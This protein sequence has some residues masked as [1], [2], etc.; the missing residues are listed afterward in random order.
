MAFPVAAD[1]AE[2]AAFASRLVQAIFQN[3]GESLKTQ[4]DLWLA[5]IPQALSNPENIGQRTVYNFVP[6]GRELSEAIPT[7]EAS[8][9]QVNA[10]DLTI[11][12]W[13]CA[14]GIQGA[15]DGSR[16]SLAQYSALLVSWNGI[17]V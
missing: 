1:F 10:N 4:L 17:W 2:A 12:L 7:I 13:Q 3:G 8:Q 11:F 14:T 16:I 15:F 9:T 5:A 6:I